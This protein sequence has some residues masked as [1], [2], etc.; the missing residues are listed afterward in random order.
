MICQLLYY[1]YLMYVIQF[2]LQYQKSTPTP[3]K[4]ILSKLICPFSPL[5][6]PFLETY[7][8][9]RRHFFTPITILSDKGVPTAP[10]PQWQLQCSFIVFNRYHNPLFISLLKSEAF[11][12]LGLFFTSFTEGF[13]RKFLYVSNFLSLHDYFCE[14]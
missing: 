1:F 3:W 11:L 4:S 10:P 5:S 8:E 14:N 9:L 2:F 13:D 6:V 7:I 12:H